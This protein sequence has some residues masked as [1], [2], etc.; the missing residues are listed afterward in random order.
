MDREVKQKGI[1]IY[2][3]CLIKVRLKGRKMGFLLVNLPNQTSTSSLPRRGV[4]LWNHGGEGMPEYV[5]SGGLL[6]LITDGNGRRENTT[7]THFFIP[8]HQVRISLLFSVSQ[9]TCGGWFI[10]CGYD[11]YYEGR[12]TEV[13]DRRREM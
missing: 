6:P 11:C 8:T 4:A 3:L 1:K 10:R 5:L 9:R 13:S 7:Q 2:N 12:D